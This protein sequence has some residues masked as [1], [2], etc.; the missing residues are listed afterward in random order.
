MA[1]GWVENEVT[2]L[3]AKYKDSSAADSFTIISLAMR[4]VQLPY[5]EHPIAALPHV[6]T[7]LVNDKLT[8]IYSTAHVHLAETCN[9]FELIIT[10]VKVVDE[11]ENGA[12]TS[13]FIYIT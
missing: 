10:A 2:Q 9:L 7:E 8:T 4:L 3:V 6:Q 1:S 5:L 13:N 12:L 11:K